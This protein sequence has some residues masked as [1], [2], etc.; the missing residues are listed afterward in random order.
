MNAAPKDGKGRAVYP[1]SHGRIST[2]EP[3]EPFLFDQL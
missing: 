3:K 2:Q 1:A